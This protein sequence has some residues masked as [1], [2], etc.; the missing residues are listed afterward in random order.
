YAQSDGAVIV[1]NRG[2]R[3]ADERDDIK[4]LGRAVARQP[5]G[6]AFQI[7]DQTVMAASR[8]TPKTRD[9]GAALHDGLLTQASTLTELAALTGLPADALSESAR[10]VSRPPFYAFACK[11]G[12]TSTYGGLSVDGALRVM[13]AEGA[14][15]GGLRAAGE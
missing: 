6:L 10:G 1:N 9:F 12:L 7:F 8:Q 15:I 3:F 14:P 11:A 4:A 13:D 2:H 5:D